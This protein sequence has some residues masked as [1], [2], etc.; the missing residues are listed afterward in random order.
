MHAMTRQTAE[1]RAD[2][3]TND[4]AAASANAA[5]LADSLATAERARN[6][7]PSTTGEDSTVDSQAE[8]STADTPTTAERPADELSIPTRLPEPETTIYRDST[9]V[10]R[11]LQTETMTDTVEV[12]L[13]R[14]VD[15]NVNENATAVATDG[16]QRRG[17]LDGLPAATRRRFEAAVD[18]AAEQFDLAVDDDG[19][20][21]ARRDDHGRAGI[22]EFAARLSGR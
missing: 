4:T 8:E 17:G 2:T 15:A 13:Y 20:F 6:T 7:D 11:L 16:G 5:S 21:R 22:L 12:R 9:T 18:T 3:T 1:H 19:R 14:A 10:I